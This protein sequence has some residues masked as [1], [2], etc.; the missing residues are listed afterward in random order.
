MNPPLL[1]PVLPPVKKSVHIPWGVEQAFRRF[2]AELATWWP[3]PTHSVGGADAV[4]C[5]FEERVGG[6][7][8]EEHGDGKRSV[9]GTVLVWEPPARVRFTWHPGEDP[10]T[11]GEVE[12]RFTP[13][14]DGTRLELEHSGW[15]RR[16]PRA[17]TIRRA[18]NLGWVYVLEI[19]AGRRGPLVRTLD[20][21][22]AIAR[23]LQRRRPG[24]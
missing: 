17:K 2:T 23:R 19:Y 12:L 16:G 20:V 4:T 14:G 21:V 7:I 8:F 22:G 24:K 15:E 6:E 1:G 5:R 10:E 3:L 18:Y 9:W 13:E 11:R